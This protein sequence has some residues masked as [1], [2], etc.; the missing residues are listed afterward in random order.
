MRGRY[1]RSRHLGPIV[2]QG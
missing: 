2:S 1:T